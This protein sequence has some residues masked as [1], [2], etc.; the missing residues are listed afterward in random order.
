[1]DAPTAAREACE[2]SG[3]RVICAGFGRTGTASLKLALERLTGGPCYHFEELFKHAEQ[4]AAWARF[5]RGEAEIDWHA[6]FEGYEAAVDFPAC[7]YYREIAAAFPDALVILSLRDLEA[8]ATS[9]DALLRYFPYF[10]AP[11]L[12]WAFPWV[13]DI[14]DVIQSVVVESTFGGAMDRM[15][16]IETHR[17]HIDTVRAAVP[18]E[19]L[20]EYRV[21]EGWEPLA[22]ALGVAVPDEPFPRLNSGTRPFVERGVRKMLGLGWKD[23]AQP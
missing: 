20:L 11:P 6:C 23:L 22:R 9:W 21:A 10:H 1:M 18:A 14:G 12:R 17:R 13:R 19:R 8:W 3:M 7:A 16:I 15:S 2:S 5:V 4:R